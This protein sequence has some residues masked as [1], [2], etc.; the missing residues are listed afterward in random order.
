MASG[1]CF[2]EDEIDI[3][4]FIDG[5]SDAEYFNQEYIDKIE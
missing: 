2:D 5:S 4:S 3:E 1:S